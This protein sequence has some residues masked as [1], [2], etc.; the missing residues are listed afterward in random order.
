MKKP[1][2]SFVVYYVDVMW[3]H[4]YN[5]RFSEFYSWLYISISYNFKVTVNLKGKRTWSA[6]INQTPISAP[7]PMASVHAWL[8]R[9]VVLFFLLVVLRAVSV[10]PF[11]FFLWDTVLGTIK[12][13]TEISYLFSQ[14]K[15]HATP[16]MTM[17]VYQGDTQHGPSGRVAFIAGKKNGKLLFGRNYR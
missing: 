5:Y 10:L 7:R 12:S 2:A 11:S 4:G 17:I 14:R 8:L 3:W 15:R 16:Y 1:R 6:P 13:S 9:V